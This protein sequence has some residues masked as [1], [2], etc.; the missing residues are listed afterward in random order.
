M[1]SHHDNSVINISNNGDN[2]HDKLN[3]SVRKAIEK[4]REYKNDISFTM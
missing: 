2:N 3:E 1:V 4:Y